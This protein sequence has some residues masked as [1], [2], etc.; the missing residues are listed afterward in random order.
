MNKEERFIVE[1]M[2]RHILDQELYINPVTNNVNIG[3]KDKAA[4]EIMEF[5]DKIK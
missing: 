1:I 2:I 4:K 5:I 3:G